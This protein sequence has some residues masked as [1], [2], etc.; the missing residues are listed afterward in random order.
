MFKNLL[1]FWKGKD[2]LSQVFGDFKDMLDDA[3]CMFDL[4]CDNLLEH[5]EDPEL[6]KKVYEIDNRINVRQKDIRKRIVEHLSLQPTVDVAACLVLMSVVKDAERLGDYA[7][8]LYRVTEFL[9]KPLD[10]ALFEKYFGQ[11]DVDIRTLFAQ[12]KE[13]FIE[14]DEDKAQSAW[15][16][17][18]RIAKLCNHVVTELADSQLTVNEAVCLALIARYLKRIVAHL[19]NIATS[20]I[21]P[22]SDLDY[23]DEQRLPE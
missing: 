1:G 23:Y 19:V 6:K 22:L 18:K 2:F 4:V 21:L 9:E 3:E 10:R 17:E 14:G 11:L 13:A 5:T 20:F 7:K 16:Y 15:D 8:N 12:T